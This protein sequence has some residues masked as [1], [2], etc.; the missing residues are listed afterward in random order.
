MTNIGCNTVIRRIL[1]L[2]VLI[3]GLSS[4]SA[5][6]NSDSEKIT[7]HLKW[8]HAFQFAGYYAAMEQGYYQSEGL[9]VDIIQ[10]SPN[11]QAINTVISGKAQYGVWGSELLNKRLLGEPIVVLAVIFQHSPY[12]VLTRKDRNIRVPSD[13][14]G[15]TIMVAAGQG[16]AQLLA[17][18][19]HEGISSDNFK[20][21]EASWR[22]DEII[23]GTVDAEMNYITDEPHQMQMLGVEPFVIK[24]IDY[25]IDFY[26]DCLFTTELE[27]SQH[28]ERVEAFKRASLKGWEYAMSHVDEMIELIIDL[29]GAKERGLTTNHLKYEAEQTEILILPELIEIGHINLGRWKHIADTYVSLGMLD[30]N[31]SLEGFIYEPEPP[32][33]LVWI[34]I[35]ILSLVIILIITLIAWAVNRQLRKVIA[36]RTHDLSESKEKFS[37]AFY[38]HPTAMQIINVKSGERIDVNNSC[39]ILFG[40]EK[41][42]FNRQNAFKHNIWVDIDAKKRGIEKIISQGFIKD[43][44]M[45]VITKS[46]KLLN[47]LA[48]GTMLGIGDGNVAIISMVDI[49]KRKIV[50]E[51]LI[52][53]KEK[54]EESNRLKT[55]FLQNISHEIRTPMNGI[56]GFAGLLQNPSLTGKEKKSFVDIILKSGKRMLNTLTD[57]MDISKVET[58]QV[59]INNSTISVHNEL[60]SLLSFFN[61]EVDSKDLELTYKSSKLIEEIEII[62]DQEKLY[63]VLSNLIKNAIK[64]THKGSIEFGCEAKG[65]MLEFYVKDTGI[66]IPKDRQSAVFERFVQADIE[67]RGVYEGQGLGLSI[68][69]AYVEMLGGE[70]W[71]D[72]IDGQGSQFYFTVPYNP[73]KNVKKTNEVDSGIPPPLVSSKELNILIAEDEEFAD[74][75][76]TI[77]LRNFSS[78]IHHAKTGKETIELCRKN[79]DLDLI[80]M[81]I[82]MPIMDGYEATRQIRE[83]NKDVIIIA[84][85]AYALSG[86]QEKAIEAGCNDY[87]SKPID[88]DELM[89]MIKGFEL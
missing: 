61:Q 62:T 68:S 45:D 29:P 19:K 55:A 46:G 48:S 86:D 15:K 71:V 42:E 58:N 72:S 23:D 76:L 75:Y 17:M 81:D 69:K 32:K 31:Y 39:E 25:G 21:V 85:T 3:I 22:M 5:Q 51:N 77:I 65:K 6:S 47:L 10:G 66:G 2:L 64:Y 4:V 41:D 82:K 84:Q 13:L 26:G 14:I 40:F 53:A 12:V 52:K 43:Y 87:I 9:D 11:N 33:D 8:M 80:L 20:I 7:L 27:I 79:P 60:E 59:E 73:V 49:T 74:E 78:K 36:R 35:V 88:K 56:I 34:Y 70:I 1:L 63:S 57:L 89:E 28:P 38:N 67:D 18:L 24:P 50:E 16:S 44:P 37:V 54:A 83:F 30:P